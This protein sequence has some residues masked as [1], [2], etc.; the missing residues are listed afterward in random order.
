M[1]SINLQ[2]PAMK[3]AEAEILR[4]PTAPSSARVCADDP[5]LNVMTDLSRQRL[6]TINSKIQIDVALAVMIH[7]KVRLL[8]VSDDNNTVDGV[9]SSYDMMGEVPLKVAARER[10]RHD[11]LSV[12]HIMTRRKMLHLLDLKIVEHARVSDVVHHLVK[13]N[14]QHALV[15]RRLE[16]ESLGICGIFSA[17]QIGAQLGRE[18]AFGDGRVESF[19]ELERLIA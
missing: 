7:A 11:A 5:A 8:L 2:S 17:S 15:V 16:D 9:V 19:A 18:I 10:I 3:S 13:L 6:V 12:A 14:Q 1:L 4:L